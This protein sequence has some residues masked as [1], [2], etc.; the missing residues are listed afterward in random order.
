MAGRPFRGASPGKPL[1]NYIAPACAE[2]KIFSIQL[3]Q[4]ITKATAEFTW[5]PPVKRQVRTAEI[6][7]T[8][9]ASVV[10]VQF[11]NQQFDYALSLLKSKGDSGK[12]RHPA[13]KWPCDRRRQQIE[14]REVMKQVCAKIFDGTQK[15]GTQDPNN[16]QDTGRGRK[17]SVSQS[18]SINNPKPELLYSSERKTM[19]PNP[20]RRV[21]KPNHFEQFDRPKTKQDLRRPSRRLNKGHLEKS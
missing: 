17:R 5:H 21:T 16:K 14:N 6:T 1:G 7:A 10:T 18:R 9:R 12:P 3:P 8:T 11:N 13:R 19:G 2:F 15:P 4:T 20:H